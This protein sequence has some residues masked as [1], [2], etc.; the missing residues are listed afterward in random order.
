MSE[1]CIVCEEDVDDRSG[2]ECNYCGETF[3]F[4]P[5]NDMPGKDCGA[6]W[7]GDELTL[8]F[9]CQNCLDEMDDGSQSV[10][11]FPFGPGVP[12]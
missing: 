2:S 6:V 7:I 4:N 10:P 8:E 3:H 11:G 12:L 1:T 9:A 5:R